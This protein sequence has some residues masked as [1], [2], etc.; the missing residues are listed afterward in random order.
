MK[1]GAVAPLGAA[2]D[3]FVVVL[4]QAASRADAIAKT[5]VCRYREFITRLLACRAERDKNKLTV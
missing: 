2:P 5:Y 3:Q 4:E 1:Y